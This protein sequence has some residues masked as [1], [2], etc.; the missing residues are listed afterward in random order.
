MSKVTTV[1]SFVEPS[2]KPELGELGLS[3][4]EIAS[5]LGARKGD[6]VKNI[7]GLINR[8]VLTRTSV[9]SEVGKNFKEIF[10]CVAEAK[11][12]VARYQNEVGE[13]YLKY[14]IARDE[15]LTR[16]EQKQAAPKLPTTFAEALRLA[17]DQAEHIEQLQA[18]LK[19]IDQLINI[20]QWFT[21][22]LS[23][24]EKGKVFKK[25]KDAGCKVESRHL[26]GCVFPTKLVSKGDLEK[27]F[28]EHELN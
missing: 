23:T 8:G 25:L 24:Y 11:F 17:A 3:A 20:D 5:S 6:V 15:V 14:L 27:V 16:F 10:L 21:R 2:F 22:K 1:P 12:V 28:P 26:S 18:E 19:Q 13:G 7:E 9:K 4:T